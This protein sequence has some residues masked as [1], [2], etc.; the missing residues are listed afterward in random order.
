MAAEYVT[1][2]VIVGNGE[3]PAIRNEN[4][5]FYVLPGGRHIDCRECAETYAGRLDA[6]ITANLTAFKRKIMKG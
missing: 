4:G 6:L 5:V 2:N 3:V 1:D